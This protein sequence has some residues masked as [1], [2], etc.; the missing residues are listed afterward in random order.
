MVE[1]SWIDTTKK[2]AEILG[3]LGAAGFFGY[4]LLAG[5]LI[6]GKGDALKILS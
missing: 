1:Y 5:Y 4:K 6:L 3:F 2:V